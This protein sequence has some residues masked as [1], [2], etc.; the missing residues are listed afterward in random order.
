MI[1]SIFSIMVG[2]FLICTAPVSQAA[3]VYVD[4]GEAGYTLEQEMTTDNTKFTISKNKTDFDLDGNA[5]LNIDSTYRYYKSSGNEKILVETDLDVVGTWAGDYKTGYD[6]AYKLEKNVL[7]GEDS[8]WRETYITTYL[9]FDYIGEE[10]LTDYY[11]YWEDM[12]EDKTGYLGFSFADSNDVINY[13][14]A[15]LFL[16]DATGEVTIY[17]YAYEDS[18]QAI[19]TGDTGSPVPVPGSLMLLG[20]GILGLFGFGHRIK[21]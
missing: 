9:F 1:K 12:D 11:T 10:D 2:I 13:G 18:G 3:I 16:D 4:Y 19:L 14:W 15:E 8:S 5:I 21:K 7:I 20:S 6:V 17:G